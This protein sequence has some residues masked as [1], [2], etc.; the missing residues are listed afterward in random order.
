MAAL[1]QVSQLGDW[2]GW[3]QARVTNERD[4]LTRLAE[5]ASRNAE[6]RCGRVFS[7]T[8]E[9]RTFTSKS[10]SDLLLGDFSAVTLVEAR[11]DKGKPFETVPASDWEARPPGQPD[12]PTRWLT[13]LRD[14]WPLAENSVRVT[15]TYGFGPQVPE[16]VQQ[17]VVMD[18]ARLVMRQQAPQ[19]NLALAG[20]G[21]YDLSAHYD[22]AVMDMLDSYKIVAVA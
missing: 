13:H 5:V 19:G 18:A 21:D 8:T 16:V 14:R 2:L 4:R 22:P 17:A 1:I 11:T 3:D 6:R 12:R 9:T 15:A 10:R 7:Q 20:G